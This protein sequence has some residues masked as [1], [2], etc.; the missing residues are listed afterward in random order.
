[1]TKRSKGSEI[2]EDI[3]EDIMEEVMFPLEGL[4]DGQGGQG[5]PNGQRA[6]QRHEGVR[7]HVDMCAR[8]F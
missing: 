2:L 8:T 4:M 5:N 7:T 3:P 6:V 1:M